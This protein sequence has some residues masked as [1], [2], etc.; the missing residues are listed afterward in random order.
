MRQSKL[1]GGHK[2]KSQKSLHRASS[3]AIHQKSNAAH[4][5][6]APISESS[7]FSFSA[8][9]HSNNGN[10]TFSSES[11]REVGDNSGGKHLQNSRHSISDGS[12]CQIRK[13]SSKRTSGATDGAALVGFQTGHSRK[14]D[15]QSCSME[16]CVAAII[17]A[18]LMRIRPETTSSGKVIDGNSADID[19]SDGELECRKADLGISFHNSDQLSLASKGDDVGSSSRLQHTNAKEMLLQGDAAPDRMDLEGGGEAFGP[20]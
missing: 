11:Q 14:D 5:S 10:F 7:N 17:D 3:L 4:I 16:E 1:P 20:F 13:V 15:I 19:L 12:Q 6:S 18:S 9:R 2:G 8:P